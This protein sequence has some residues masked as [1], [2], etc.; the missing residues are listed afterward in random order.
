[1]LEPT[2]V[3]NGCSWSTYIVY[4]DAVVNITNT[5]RHALP[6]VR[7][8]CLVRLCYIHLELRRIHCLAVVA[9]DFAVRSLPPKYI[10][11]VKCFA[12]V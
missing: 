6:I 8:V 11:D 2:R 1:M 12:K 3:G 10:L 7:Q 9:Y 4:G 5:A